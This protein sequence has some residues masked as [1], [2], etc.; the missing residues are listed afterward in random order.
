MHEVL[1]ENIMMN[2]TKYLIVIKNI[3]SKINGHIHTQ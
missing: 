3:A 2:G 1:A